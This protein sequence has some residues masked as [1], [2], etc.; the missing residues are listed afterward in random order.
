M[1]RFTKADIDAIRKSGEFDEKWYLDQYPD[2]RALGMDPVEHYLW[3]GARMGRR[4]SPDFRATGGVPVGGNVN[5]VD[6]DPLLRS[7]RSTQQES[8]AESQPAVQPPAPLGH[9]RHRLK[10]AVI[11]W[12]VAHNPLGRAYLVAEALSRRFEVVLLGPLFERFGKRIWSPVSEGPIPVISFAGLNYPEFA[13][14]LDA[15]A[16]K[17]DCDAIVAC[18]PRMPSLHLALLAKK[19]HSRPIVI[20]IDDHE[21]AFAEEFSPLHLEELGRRDPSRLIE[22]HSSDWTRFAETLVPLGD[23]IIVSNEELQ[24][25]FG[26]TLVP[27]ARD[28]RKF[29]PG[30]FDR[31]QVR[32]ELGFTPSDRVVFFA[33][34]ARAHKGIVELATA[35]ASL[36]KPDYKLA[37]L[38]TIQ[39]RGL[40]SRIET[41]GNGQV[42]F[43]PNQPLDELP[44]FL[45]SADLVCL[46]Q[47]PDSAISRFQLPAKLIDAISMG[48]PVL[49]TETPPLARFV[50]NGTVMPVSTATLAQRID[51]CLANADALRDRQLANRAVFLREFSYEAVASTL[52]QVVLDAL[53]NFKPL[54]ESAL[55]FEEKMK[56]LPAGVPV[57]PARIRETG[58]YD[59]VM[60]WK[61][62]DTGVY[63]RRSDML[64]KY[65][66]R[67][68]DVR[69]V[70]ML[71]APL[72]HG[73][74]VRR[75]EAG[76]LSEHRMVYREIQARSLGLRDTDYLSFHS[77]IYHGER[78]HPLAQWRY[79]TKESY[80]A[81]VAELFRARGV[82]P[83]RALFWLFPVN[84]LLGSVVERFSP[85]KVVC[86][87]VDDQRMHP[88]ISA[89]RRESY[90]ENY[91][92]L[93]SVSD[94]AITNCAPIQQSMSVLAPDMKVVPNAFDLDPPTIRSDYDLDRLMAIPG[95]RLGYVGNLE[96]KIDV[97]LLEQ[98]ALRRPDWN[99][100]LVG[101][102]HSRPEILKLDRLPNIHF[103]GVVRYDEARLWM[104][105]FDV[106]IMPH[107]IT[108]LTQTMNPL[109]LFVY[110]AQRIPVVTT[111]TPN[112]ED[113]REFISTAYGVDE[114]ID[115]IG[116]ALS[117]ER[118]PDWSRLDQVL[119][120]N[121]WAARIEDVMN[122]I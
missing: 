119:S 66:A 21:L 70:L 117:G 113:L 109:K 108:P 34:T 37:V 33:G 28:E 82:E 39:D 103:M 121:S 45:V 30:R 24:G 50:R 102:T 55:A 76:G 52:E 25:Q 9:E 79:P 6:A 38:G 42:V 12:D 40:R 4:P 77:F 84:N 20:D 54:S 46:L 11:S 53:G 13:D 71:D 75:S 88:G 98:V 122:W 111:P 106:G 16:E 41:A 23:G 1:S 48:V 32:S 90:E 80:L 96:S 81:W 89:Q 72:W 105:H 107:L 36:G 92:Q 78:R 69:Q 8:R 97:D 91:R 61:Q 116:M 110:L 86:D 18:K 27:H 51:D 115:C 31:E 62:N 67:H 29:D 26:G 74:L 99:I 47:N 15:I 14:S 43:F 64:A 5:G 104:T 101:S 114:F 73:D 58:T 63:G 60:F 100:V 95:P 120:K 59:V 44:R 7:V 65:L 83:H 87:V 49:A 94:L 10:V 85:A 112:T 93:L 3:L 17:L 118:R 57:L 35:I 22:P 56:R 19:H 68:P 2:V